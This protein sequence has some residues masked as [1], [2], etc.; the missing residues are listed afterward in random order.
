M[1]K[2]DNAKCC[3]GQNQ[4]THIHVI[5]KKCGS[6]DTISHEEKAFTAWQD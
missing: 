6:V 5:S 4:T 3:W 2:Q 1:H